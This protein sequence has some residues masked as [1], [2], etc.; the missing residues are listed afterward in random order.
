MP[1]QA[2]DAATARSVRCEDEEPVNDAVAC[3]IC[4]CLVVVIAVVLFYLWPAKH[5]DPLSVVEFN[6][7]AVLKT[8]VWPRGGGSIRGNGPEIVWAVFFYKPYCG[9]C[10]RVW[11]SARAPYTSGT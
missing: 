9:A 1:E 11:P 10:R 7:D 3:G 6:N 2:G 4:S 5:G 8:V